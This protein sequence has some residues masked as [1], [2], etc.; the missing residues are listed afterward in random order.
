ME[1]IASVVAVAE[2]THVSE[3][4]RRAADVSRTLALDETTSGRVAL[5]VTEAATNLLK[6][7]GGGEVFVGITGTGD[8]SGVQIIAMDRGAGIRNVSASLAD[9]FSTAGS[10]G[11]GLG[12]IRRSSDSF[13]IYS[14]T[15]G[16]VVAASVY[17][18]R[19]RPVTPQIGAVCVPLR[20]EHECGD[21]W[22]AWSAG[23][24]TSVFVVDGLGHGHEAALAA[25]LAVHTFRR[26]AER[27]APEVISLVHAALKPTRGAAVALA[28]LDERAGKLR[29]CAIGNI[30]ALVM[31]P[32]GQEQHLISLPGIAGHVARRVQTFTYDW[33]RGSLLVMHSDGVGTHW[34]LSKYAGLQRHRP[35]VVAGVLFRDHRRGTDDAT[36]VVTRHGEAA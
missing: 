1:V 20:G 2:A 8:R 18:D 14:T 21:A 24:L 25:E 19:T 32:N 26:H 10:A 34:S 17:A 7:A 4:R 31:R 36:A 30:S 3:A 22:A 9:G 13:D 35:D 27:A 29:Y 12:A 11:T 28:E 16:T 6:H 23:G 33:P 15:T 5:V